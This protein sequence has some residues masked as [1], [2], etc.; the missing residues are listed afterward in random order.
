LND[1]DAQA[2]HAYLLTVEARPS[3]GR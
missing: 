2:L 1:V 3:G